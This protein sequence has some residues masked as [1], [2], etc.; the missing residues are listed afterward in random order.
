M[1]ESAKEIM[2][3]LDNR[4]G[5]TRLLDAALLGKGTFADSSEDTSFAPP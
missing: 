1:L 3:N 5:H 2:F 4:H